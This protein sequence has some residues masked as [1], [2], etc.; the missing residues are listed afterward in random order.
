MRALVPT[1]SHVYGERA[2]WVKGIEA[3]MAKNHSLTVVIRQGD[4]SDPEKTPLQ[5]LPLGKPVPIFCIAVPGDQ[6]R[7]VAAQFEDDDGTTVFIAGRLVKP[8]GHVVEDDLVFG[9]GG[10][11]PRTATEVKNYL[12][13]ELC[14]GKTFSPDDL[15]TIYY[16]EYLP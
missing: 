9:R 16:V 15:I 12:E 7:G 8:L 2:L 13:Q 5:W 10:A 14:P 11:I 4:R 3:A 1:D 6:A